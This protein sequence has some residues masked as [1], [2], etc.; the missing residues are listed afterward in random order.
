MEKEVSMIKKWTG[1]KVKGHLTG[2]MARVRV[3]DLAFGE[4]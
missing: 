1:I 2:F 3:R 4:L